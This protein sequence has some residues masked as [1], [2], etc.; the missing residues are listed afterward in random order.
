MN[1]DLCC[2]NCLVIYFV[3]G[4]GLLCGW[5]L[6]DWFGFGRWFGYRFWFCCF[7][8][9]LMIF[10][11]GCLWFTVVVVSYLV[12]IGC[13]FVGWLLVDGLF[14]FLLILL[15][16]LMWVWLFVFDTFGICILFD[17]IVLLFTCF[18]L[19]CTLVLRFVLFGWCTYRFGS[20]DE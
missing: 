8:Y 20:F 1:F 10:L 9:L 14:V 18:D 6:I 11:T 4:F 19:N 2:W 17:F 13:L 7:Y 12:F 3:V 15:C 16:I 5:L